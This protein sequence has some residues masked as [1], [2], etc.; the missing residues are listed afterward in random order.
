[1]MKSKFVV[2]A[3]IA[4]FAVSTA[5]AAQNC[6]PVKSKSSKAA[7]KRVSKVGTACNF[8]AVLNSGLLDEDRTDLSAY[9]KNTRLVE[10]PYDENVSYFIKTMDN[11]NTNLEVPGKEIIQGFYLSDPIQWEFHVTGDK[12]RVL[13]KPKGIGLKTTGTLVTDQRSYELTLES[14]GLGKHWFQRVRWRLPGEGAANGVYWQ[15][16]VGE[17]GKPLNTEVDGYSIDPEKMRFDYVVKGSASFRPDQ[18]FDDGVRT[19]FRIGKPQ[20]VPAVFAIDKDGELDVIDYIVKADYIIA[21][22]IAS[23]FVMKLN[24]EEVM[25]NKKACSGLFCRD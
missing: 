7:S 3:V 4:A 23:K 21:P 16:T 6:V 14:V 1:M 11:V 2:A 10:F 12:R 24:G 18:V 5:S 19:Y 17:D 9:S 15:P 8:E 20:D 22:R 25:I 13:V